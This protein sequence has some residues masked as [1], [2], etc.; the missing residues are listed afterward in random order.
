MIPDSVIKS[1]FGDF[2][3]PGFF[4]LYRPD[5]CYLSGKHITCVEYEHS[6]RGMVHHA[7]KYLF[8]ARRFTQ[9]RFKVIFIES[10]HHQNRH[11]EDKLLCKY[12]LR[13]IELFNIEFSVQLCTGR[14]EDLPTSTSLV[15]KSDTLPPENWPHDDWYKEYQSLGGQHAERR[16]MHNVQVFQDLTMESYTGGGAD[17]DTREVAWA[18]WRKYI[19]SQ[20]EAKLYFA[21][22]DNITA[23]T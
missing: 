20:K 5:F 17:T 7:A 21:A 6:S 18:K 3:T 10:L 16:F 15:V 14:L 8:L 13:D 1:H 22:V 12:L 4:G 19:G 23:Y 2:E 9:Y 11:R